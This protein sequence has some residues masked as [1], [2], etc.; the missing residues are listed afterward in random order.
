[1]YW[2]LKLLSPDLAE[3]LAENRKSYEFSSC[4]ELWVPFAD[5]LTDTL[6]SEAPELSVTAQVSPTFP[7]S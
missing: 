1:L 6:E 2:H 7:P 3:D 4:D 5:T